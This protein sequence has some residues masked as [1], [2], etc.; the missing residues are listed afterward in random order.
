MGNTQTSATDAAFLFFAV[1]FLTYA[2]G[3]VCALRAHY[4]VD[5]HFFACGERPKERSRNKRKKKSRHM[6]F[7]NKDDIVPIPESEINAENGYTPENVRAMSWYEGLYKTR[8][9]PGTIAYLFFWFIM[10]FL[11]AYVTWRIWIDVP[12]KENAYGVLYLFFFLGHLLMLI[13]ANEMQF[14]MKNLTFGI[15]GNF[16]LLG[17]TATLLGFIGA[18]TF[19]TNLLPSVTLFVLM[20]IYTQ[21]M[22]IVFIC[23]II[24]AVK[25]PIRR[26]EIAI[27]YT[28]VDTEPR[29]QPHY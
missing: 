12:A 15:L 29:P 24:L 2:I 13:I 26:S 1:Y 14:S 19:Q 6:T 25:N 23:S 11:V 20:C 18:L 5:G 10:Y 22:L 9:F 7:D 3:G 4:L 27:M 28:G 16:L 17:L 8:G 21:G